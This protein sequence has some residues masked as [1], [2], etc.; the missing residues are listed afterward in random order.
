[1]QKVW[2]ITCVTVFQVLCADMGASARHAPGILPKDEIYCHNK[3]VLHK[4]AASCLYECLEVLTTL[5]CGC[6]LLTVSKQSSKTFET[7]GLIIHIGKLS[8]PC[9]CNK[10]MSNL[11]WQDFSA[12]IA[13]YAYFEKLVHA[14][15]IFI[16]DQ[17]SNRSLQDVLQ[18]KEG[19]LFEWRD[20]F[21]R[22]F[23]HR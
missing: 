19:D 2:C 4:W 5:F 18:K 21:N 8:L 3:N 7:T 6:R 20:I 1:M 10:F 23:K 16:Q 22:F 15:M 14:R 17:P 13:R 9:L 12:L 11:A